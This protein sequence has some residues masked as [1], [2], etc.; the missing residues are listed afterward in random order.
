MSTHYKTPLLLIEF[1]GDRAFALQVRG[2][3]STKRADLAA[4]RAAACLRAHAKSSVRVGNTV[5]ARA[6]PPS[7]K[8]T[9]P[10]LE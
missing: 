3:G 1:E 5:D 8:C 6:M 7:K 4:K 9:T 2:S 10:G